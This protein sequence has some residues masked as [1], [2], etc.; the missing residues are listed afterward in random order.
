MTRDDELISV[1][2]VKVFNILPTE[3]SEELRCVF[4]QA[5]VSFTRRAKLAVTLEKVLADMELDA[6]GGEFAGAVLTVA[7]VVMW[8]Y[9]QGI[10]EGG[11]WGEVYIFAIE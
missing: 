4:I 11:G 7:L 9:L 6:G 1:D 3:S 5:M 8:A 10:M 2:L